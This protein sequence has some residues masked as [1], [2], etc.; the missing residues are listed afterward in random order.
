M[1]LI[2]AEH[3]IHLGSFPSTDAYSFLRDV[4]LIGLGC[5]LHVG[6]SSIVTQ[7]EH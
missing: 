7:V 5:G 3:W 4:D 6:I 1:I 2:L